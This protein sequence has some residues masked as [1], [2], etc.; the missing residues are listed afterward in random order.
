MLT[1]IQI[2]TKH[3]IPT[4][5]SYPREP[6]LFDVI[7]ATYEL[8]AHQTDELGQAFARFE[9]APHLPNAHAQPTR[10]LCSLPVMRYNVLVLDEAHRIAN[11]KTNT[12]MAMNSLDTKYRLAMTGT[13][14]QNECSDI[15]SLFRFLKVKYWCDSEFFKQVSQ[16]AVSM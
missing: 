5:S 14:L 6:K 1:I 4:Q 8:T 13:P 11:A 10:P 9:Q 15:Q 3:D 2:L 12:F 16:E 7:S